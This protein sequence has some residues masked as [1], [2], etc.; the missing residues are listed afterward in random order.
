VGGKWDEIGRLQLDG[1][2]GRG[3]KPHHKLCDA[4]CGSL[5]AG[6]HFVNYLDAGN[7]YGL[8]INASLID[9]GREELERGGPSGKEANLLVTDAF[10]M[11]GFGATFDYII[12]FS[13]FTH[14]HANYIVRCLVEARKT[15]APD[16][17]LLATIFFAPRPAHLE[18]IQHKAGGVTSYYDKDPFHYS[19]EEIGFLGKLAGFRTELLPPGERGGQQRGVVFW[20]A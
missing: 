18:P 4:G 19:M 14:L 5:R 20:P 7:Y 12:A 10:E 17:Q 8:D 15:I 9:A 16:G 3:L 11:S 6:V 1:L 2:I 13:L